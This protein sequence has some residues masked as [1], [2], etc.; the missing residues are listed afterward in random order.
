[1]RNI[2]VFKCLLFFSTIFIYTNVSAQQ[3]QD[4]I[5]ASKK[6]N[7][8]RYNFLKFDLSKR[9]SLRN[10]TQPERVKRIFGL[11]AKHSFVQNGSSNNNPQFKADRNGLDHVRYNQYFNGVKVEHGIITLH[12]KSGEL[13]MVSGDYLNIDENF[14][15]TPA[16]AENVALN[17]AIAFV[18]ASKYS[19]QDK[20]F[21]NPLVKG[22]PKGELVISRN[23]AEDATSTSTT[24]KAELAYKFAI[25]ATEPLR[26]DNIYVSA[27]TGKIILVDPIIKHVDGIAATRYSGSRTITTTQLSGSSYVLRD[28]GGNYNLATYNLKRGSGYNIASDFSDSDNNWTAAEYNNI[29][30]DNAALDAHWGA[31]MT[32]DYWRTVHNRNSF[33]NK[34]SKIN[35]YVHYGNLY[36]NAFWDGFEMTYGDG[37]GS[38][39]FP[40]TSIDICG[41]EI[42]HG[43]CQYTAN[44]IYSN[45][46]GAMNEGFSDIWGACIK[47]FADPSKNTWLLGEEIS[48]TQNPI[49]SMINPK[50][51]GQPDTYKGINWYTGTADNG[52]VHTNSG[53]LNY[54]FYLLS[55]G[56]SG[57]N[58]KGVAYNVSG[59]GMTKASQIA[60]RAENIYL[61]PA[62]TYADAR[63]YT[64][65]AAEDLFGA[66]SNEVIQTT[67]A[68]KAVGVNDVLARPDSLSATLTNNVINVS[69]RFSST[70]SIE[71][72]HIER[73]VNGFDNF[74]T[75]AIVSPDVRNFTD[76]SYT[77][78]SLNQ[79]RIRTFRADSTFSTYSLVASVPVGNAPLVMTN[80]SYSTCASTFFDP[81][82]QGN[83]SS[84]NYIMTLRPATTGN[85]LQVS[86]SLFNTYDYLY[87]YNGP[88]ASSPLLGVFYGTT[89]PPVLQST[90]AG[91][92]LTFV[93]N[94]SYSSG[95]PGWKANVTCFK[96]VSSPSNLIA[97]IDS[98]KRVRLTWRD[99]ANDETGYT[100]ERSVNDS[101]HFQSYTTLAANAVEYTDSLIPDNSYVFYRVRAY[102]DTTGSP[103]SNIAI[104]AV[105]NLYAMQSGSLTTCATTFLD[106]GGS[107][108]YNSGYYT[109]T[110]RPATTGNKLKIVFNQFNVGSDYLYVYNGPSSSS[111][112]LGSYTGSTLPPVLQSTAAGGE[113]TFVFNPSYSNSYPGWSAYINCFK[114]VGAPTNLSATKNNVKNVQLNWTDN[115]NDEAGFIVER[116]INDSLHYLSLVNLTANTT[117]YNDTLAPDNSYIYYRIKAYR[118]TAASLYSNAVAIVNGNQYV[119]Q[120][121]GSYAACNYTFLDPGG[122]GSYTNGYYTTTLRP[123]TTGN[124][125]KIVFSQFNIGYDNLYIYNGPSSASPLLGSYTGTSVPPAL[126]S[127]AKG[128]ELTFVFNPYYANVLAGWAANVT[129]YKPVGKPS[130][131]KGVPDSMRNINI[132]WTDNAD[133]ETKFVVERSVNAPSKYTVIAQL[134]P[135]TSQYTDTALP[136]NS[137]VFYRIRAY[138]DTLASLY[139]DTAAVAVGNA[140]LLM[141]DTTLVTC[142]K[143]FLDQG[144]VDVMPAGTYFSAKTTFK[145]AIAGNHVKVVFSK[146]KSYNTLYV[147]NGPS[148]NSPLLASMSYNS[149]APLTYEGTGADGS[150]TFLYGGS[151]YGDSGWVAQVSCYKAVAKPTGITAVVSGSQNVNLKWTDNADDEN[152]YV[153]ERS[154]NA[155]AQYRVIGE[156]SANATTYLDSVAPLNSLIFYRVRAI[157]NSDSSY[158]SDTATVGVGNAPFL[159]KDSTLITCDKVFM[160]AGGTDIVPLNNNNYIYVR[161]TFKPAVA[162]NNINVSFSKLRL[163]GSSLTVFN[164]SSSSSPQIGTYNG[165]YNNNTL[166][167]NSTAADGALTFIQSGYS[168]LDSGWVAQVSCFKPVA[169]PTN[170]KLI[171]DSVAGVKLTWTDNADDETRYVVERSVNSS[172]LFAPIAQLPSNTTQYTDSSAQANSILFYRLKAYRDTLGSVYSDTVVLNFGNAPFIMKDSIV[173]TCD[174]VFLDPGGAN[175]IPQQ[176][177][178]Y[179]IRTTFKPAIT[180]NNIRIV[181]SKLKI[182]GTIFVYNGASTLGPSIGSYNG[183]SATPLVFNSTA[184][185]GSLTVNYQS[186]SYLDSGW[187][188]QVSCYKAVAKPTITKAIDSTQF[189]KVIWKDNADDET[190][191]VLERS[192]NAT[193]MFSAIAQL[194]ANSTQYNDSTA[195]ANSLLYYRVKAYRD[196]LPSLYSDTASL[197][198]GNTPV[199][200]KDTTITTCDK[201]FMD[202]G[203][204]DVIPQTNN[205]NSVRTTFK[206]AI[207]GNNVKVVFSKFRI[208]N[209]N[210]LVYNGSSTSSPLIANLNGN[211]TN[212]SALNLSATGVDGALTFLYQGYSYGDSGWVAQ[213]SCYKP[214]AKPS[215]LKA[216]IDASQRIGL[217]WTD[218][219]E[220]ETKY[221]VERSVNASTLYKPIAVLPS[222]TTQYIDSTPVANSLL[223]YKVKAYRDTLS[224]LPDSAVVAYGNAP[225]IMKDST[226]ITCDKVFMDPAGADDMKDGVVYN[227]RTTFKPA[228]DGTNIKVVFN[229]FSLYNYMYVYNGSSTNSPPMGGYTSTYAPGSLVFKGT[230]PDHSLTFLYQG[231][232][233]AMGW[234]AKV[235]CYI[236]VAPP[237]NFSA[238]KGTAKNI[239]LKWTDNA[240][241][242]NS[243]VVERSLNDTIHYQ[244]IV[245]LPANTLEYVDSAAPDNSYIYY[246]V[247]AYLDSSGSDYSN[248]AYVLTGEP[249]IMQNAA[250]TTCGTIF[251]DP[252]DTGNYNTG[253]YTATIKPATAGNNIRVQFSQFNIGSESLQ[254]Y[255]GPSVA[256]PRLGIYSG[257][258]IPPMLQSTAPGGELT[259]VF[260]SYYSNTAAGWVAY[261]SCYKPVP[262]PSGVKAIADSVKGV[263]L[264]WTDNAND[265]TRYVIERSVNATSLYSTVAQLPANSIQY[266]D[267]S[268]PANSIIYYRVKAYRDTLGSPYSDTATFNFGNAPFLMK[269]STLITCDKI[270]MD[271]GGA[272]VIP[273][274]SYYSTR[275]TFKPSVN[276]NR[277]KVTFTKF[278]L[279]GTLYVYNGSSTSAPLVGSYSGNTNSFSITSTAVDGS[280]TFS[281]SGYSYGDSGWIAQVSCYKSVAAPTGTKASADTITAVKLTWTDNADDETRYM[282]ERS[283][284]AYSLFVPIAQLPANSVQYID[285][286][287]PANSLISY[288]VKAYRDTLGSLYG[289]TVTIAI[290]NAPF[291][292]KDSTV[293]TCN[294]VFMDP[295]GVDVISANTYNI[296]RT[297]FKPGV[298]GNVIQVTFS[299]LKISG[300]LYVYNGPSTNSPSIGNLSSGS[301]P[302]SVF[303]STAADG[304]LTFYY[305][306]SYYADSGWIAQVSCIK[307][308]SKPSGIKAEDDVVKGVKVTWNDNA[309]DETKYVLERSVNSPSQFKVLA[310]LPANATQ[311]TDSVP[312]ANILIFYRIRGYRDTLTS[313]YSDT[314]TFV[315][316]NAPFLMKDSTLIT[317]NKVFMDAGGTD[318]LLPNVYYNNRTTF[319]PSTPGNN[320]T[321]SFSKLAISGT[322]YVYNGPSANSPL[323]GTASG[324]NST[325]L[326]TASGAD[327][328]LTFVYSGYSYN[329]SG[330]IAQVGCIKNV[331]KPSA[332]KATLDSNQSIKLTWTDNADDETRYVIE[333]SVNTASKFLF[334]GQTSAN[335]TQ[336]IDFAAPVN[337][338][339]FYRVRAFRDNT[340][341]VFSDTAIIELGNAPFLMKDSTLITCSKVFMDPGGTDVIPAGVYYNVR[342]T[343]KP[344]VAGNNI[345]VVFSK[346]AISGGLSVYNGSS[347]NSPLLGTF[348]S[349]N[350]APLSFS[351]TGVDGSLTILYQGSSYSDSGW[352]ADVSCYKPVSAPTNLIA[353]SNNL[354]TVQLNWTDNAMDETSYTLERSFNDTLNFIPVKTL[355]ANSTGYTDT[356]APVNSYLFYRVKARRDSLSSLYSNIVS[357]L[358]GN[359][360]TMRSGKLT[361]CGITFLD[362]G[363]AANYGN[364]I[365]YTTTFTPAEAAKKVRVTFSQFNT[366]SCCDYLTV[367]NGPG[368]SSP[369]IGI[370]LSSSIPPVLE[371]S[372]P[373][374]EL[375]FKFVSDGATTAP[376]WIANITCIQTNDTLANCS[377]DSN[378]VNTL[379][380]NLTGSGYQWQKYNGKTYV[381]IYNDANTT[382]TSTMFLSIKNAALTVFEKFRCIVNGK[383]SRELVIIKGNRWTGKVST[384]WNDAQ[385]WS[386]GTAP[387]ATTDILIEAG[388]VNYPII[389]VTTEC[390]SL[391]LMPGARLNV[392]PGVNLYIRH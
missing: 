156:T 311:F 26:Y 9:N 370:Y 167:F 284:N 316:G 367:Y 61:Y 179:N 273:S 247:I 49:R 66:G 54:W 87:V 13:S 41:H 224:S 145:P 356:S 22:W 48:S 137:L 319:K 97:A 204:S 372:A 325:P 30:Y 298:A 20:T 253:S 344:G 228:T 208:I 334:V 337:S 391:K 262:K 343:F 216:T 261:A 119:M 130:S 95:A 308:V 136:V 151:S 197:S 105:G 373:G 223:F 241:N 40:L 29:N 383:P 317:C 69:W 375:S 305:Y 379:T 140:P 27:K 292:M 174:K 184:P 263:K 89:L 45:E 1:M 50:S 332:V 196:T 320:I 198:F 39:M 55:M 186:Y 219:A 143:V 346:V 107:G 330:W 212:T 309:N 4:N 64:I 101:L 279:S 161:T 117:S 303:T 21:N 354:K 210:L 150:L 171:A 323:L 147:Y 392:A 59:I 71:G 267:S 182:N 296:V 152:K 245:N 282:V 162:G 266:I 329:D 363:G 189:V 377:K 315:N 121:T 235:S 269:D 390:R 118:D 75:I 347:T 52:G 122:T 225:F 333:R 63:I 358:N 211:Y 361:A 233:P 135:N 35:S 128:G 78:N 158:Y 274:N 19:W 321:V 111:P 240:N 355:A 252:G 366:E 306:S 205:Y 387:D 23:F 178:Y 132:T 72:F 86:F 341:S 352:I 149:V 80:G 236:P 313:A 287:A 307:S 202:A 222:N 155:P 42:G 276:G 104:I 28:S 285:N 264:T 301:N 102:R 7:D 6:T 258:A 103:Y 381:N 310:Q 91:G 164:G 369:I 33:D 217:T 291:L 295:A 280:L 56:K 133:D 338:L 350:S 38:T 360:F 53:I 365:N 193:T 244:P 239:N 2:S 43:V 299:K 294:K 203:G 214:V 271:P 165:S 168:N 36:A 181:F 359:V 364:N 328:S 246:R 234:E 139:S 31:M 70:Q 388:M 5:I 238:V 250:V 148:T 34:G 382:G 326:F 268:A 283:I 385:N 191:V 96:P 256:S 82:G 192:V 175:V 374:G 362:P 368:A 339:L 113:L 100:V 378:E 349:V 327:G 123:A 248:S 275:T 170:I 177:N 231:S 57:T 84:G 371:S 188:A 15:T 220:D 331:A 146:Y 176:S 257:A 237:T 81:G 14:S 201:I 8:G 386:C 286:S 380:A 230:G 180:G 114:P 357:V 37:D 47:K 215:A 351:A 226:L 227:Y 163:N 83:Y 12:R 288:R 65:Q 353:S 154:V 218:N 183:N 120:T 44:L 289:D 153:I 51:K 293:I 318:V 242:E 99:N 270:F 302:L 77:N 11:G 108:N 115:A 159:I 206:P 340:T 76:S 290:G 127:T 129:C 138:R 300:N 93:L 342:T 195:P 157:R 58:D 335:A 17:N 324:S 62:A 92:E 98:L 207:A 336:F 79:Y 384:D 297:T 160:D 254:I 173:V 144:G 376:G 142:D 32:L 172:S 304:S 260:N 190:R 209:G 255:N 200:M 249:F 131:V 67:E 112:W 24:P 232:Y 73:A 278:R 345:K 185:D 116:S 194:P 88:D 16:I 85:K 199:F 251:L 3:L 141:T 124:N 25:Y 68:W 243:Y 10:E 166:S 221:V 60:Y 348:N 106:P 213:V 74:V 272:D 110:I 134:Q 259:F 18:G 322:L 46:S 389:N 126:Q 312:P 229:K 90:A 169:R 265:E 187:V 109:T 314:A 281:Y 277:L 94:A 125:L